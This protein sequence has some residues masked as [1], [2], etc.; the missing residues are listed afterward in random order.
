MN[1]RTFLGTAAA[2]VGTLA[3]PGARAQASAAARQA[4]SP[5]PT[6]LGR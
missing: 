3:L 4:N 2:G 6:S 5:Q 1:R